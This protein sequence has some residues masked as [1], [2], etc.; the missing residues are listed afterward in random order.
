MNIA[1]N[2]GEEIEDETIPD[3]NESLSQASFHSTPS[4]KEGRVLPS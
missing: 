3:E 2:P 1:W 4:A